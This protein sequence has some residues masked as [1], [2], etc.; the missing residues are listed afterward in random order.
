MTRCWFNWHGRR[1]GRSSNSAA[2]AHVLPQRWNAT[3]RLCWPPCSKRWPVPSPNGP[4][5]PRDR[6]PDPEST[7]VL[8][9][10]QAVLKSRAAME[11]IA[12][13]MIATT[14][15]LQTP[16]RACLTRRR[17][18]YSVLRGWRRQLVGKRSCMSSPGISRCG[19]TLRRQTA[20]RTSG[21]FS[22]V[23]TNCAPCPSHDDF[24]SALSSHIIGSRDRRH[25][26]ARCGV[27]STCRTVPSATRVRFHPPGESHQAR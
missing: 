11:N 9:L 23:R 12:P 18:G 21:P 22:P 4:D 10:L 5:V 2:C 7:G 26:S 8:E 13:T 17:A 27:P 25:S 24:T 1:R 6:K 19:S 15:D 3:D 16:R 20:L 14:G